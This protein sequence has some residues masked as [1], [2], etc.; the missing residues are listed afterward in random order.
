[1]IGLLLVSFMTFV[2]LNCENLFDTQHDTLKNDYEFL[3]D[4]DH[5]WT[6]TRYWRKLNHIGQELIALGEDSAQ[7][8]HLPDVVILCE[9]ENDSVMYDLTR[10]SLLRHAKYEYIMTRSPDQRGIDVALLYNPYAFLPLRDISFRIQPSPGMRPTRDLLYVSG[11]LN[12]GDTLHIF[13]IHAPSRM[14]GERASRP[15]RLLV[16][17]RLAE[18][19]DSIRAMTPEANIIIAGDFND[20]KDSPVLKKLYSMGFI[21]LSQDA[22]G[23]HGAKGTYRFRGEWG[24]LDHI[25]CSLPVKTS[26]INCQ[27]GDLEFILEPDEK[28][29]GVKPFRTYMG[30]A[31]HSGYSDHLPL[32]AKFKTVKQQY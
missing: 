21:N 30:P 15:H 9:V 22:R 14:G 28:Y 23:R 29:G 8:W 6:R 1:M 24:S 16:E 3:P 32:V 10:R 27:I 25:L 26:F 31:Y 18:A 11:K 12:N 2:E 20:Y 13:G 17:K 5:H 4:G 7:Q 19:I